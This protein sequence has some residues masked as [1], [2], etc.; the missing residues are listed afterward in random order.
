MSLQPF[1]IIATTAD[2]GVLARGGTCEEAFVHAAEGLFSLIAD[3][4]SV[5]PAQPYTVQCEGISLEGLLVAWLNELIYLHDA[6]EILLRRFEVTAFDGQKLE[7]KVWGEPI[8]PSRHAL[9]TEVKAATYH[10]A[11]VMEGPTGWEAKVILDV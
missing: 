1:E 10:Q 7:A 5:E 4:D 9:G 3:L 2:V 6:H 8:D 11:Q